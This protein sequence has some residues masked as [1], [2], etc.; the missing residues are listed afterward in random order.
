MRIE[1]DI[2]SGALNPAWVLNA[3]DS[4]KLRRLQD[5]L[6]ACSDVPPAL[7]G[8]GYRGF[9]YGEK[10]GRFRA[11]GGYIQSSEVL[12]IDP[13]LSIELFLRDRLPTQ[14][15]HLRAKLEPQ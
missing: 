14:Y 8:L 3:T 9:C 4:R 13:E 10:P 6:K 2:F 11:Y 12:L 5:K 1:L 7:P 15:A